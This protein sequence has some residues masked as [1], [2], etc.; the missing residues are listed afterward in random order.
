MAIER[1]A[2]QT[3]ARA[4]TCEDVGCLCGEAEGGIAVLL[5]H[6][7][8]DP[9]REGLR[10][11]PARVVRAFREMTA[12]YHE[13]PV[14]ILSTS[15]DATYDEM[16]VLKDILFTS[17]CEHHLLPFI[18][19]ATVGYIPRDR[20]VGLSKLAR[21]TLCFARRLQLQERMTT[22][23]ANALMDNLH[24]LGVGVIVRAQHQ[25][26]ACRGVSLAGATM[27]TSALY[28]MM[29]EGTVREEFLR[30]S[31]GG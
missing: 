6:L 15:F 25:C 19:V 16:V 14:K 17:L 1:T 22:Q 28:G 7:G 4:L 20:V 26:M 2:T 10:D 24:P 23:I 18:G 13:D 5:K 21:V 30:L 12:G 3:M 27:V 8:E 29:R 31:N 11:T 9:T